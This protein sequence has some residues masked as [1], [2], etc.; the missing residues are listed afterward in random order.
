M[1]VSKPEVPYRETII[2]PPKYDVMNEY[3]G[4]QEKDFMT[5]F[6]NMKIEDKK[7]GEVVGEKVEN[8]KSKIVSVNTADGRIELQIE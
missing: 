2:H 6:K 8:K 4:G 5:K 7:E 1:S 3:I